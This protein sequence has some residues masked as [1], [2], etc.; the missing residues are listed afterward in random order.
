MERDHLFIISPPR[1]GSTFLYEVLSLGV[2]TIELGYESDLAW[3][4]ALPYSPQRGF[5]DFVEEKD[6]TNSISKKIY[7]ETVN[8]AYIQRYGSYIRY[9]LHDT[10]GKTPKIYLDKTIA[11]CFH[12]NILNSI[13]GE[14]KNRVKLVVLLRNPKQTISSMMEGWKYKDLMGKPQID[15]VLKRIENRKIEHWSFPIPPRWQENVN[16]PLHELCAWSWAQHVEYIF[17]GIRKNSYDYVL[18]KYE[19]MLESITNTIKEIE[20]NLDVN[21]GIDFDKLKIK[22]SR[23]TISPPNQDKWLVNKQLI[24]ESLSSIKDTIV[25]IPYVID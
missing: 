13:Y 9:K 24:Q 7:S 22:N 3:W 17:D 4:S 10:L 16:K 14:K 18:I 1:S 8:R 12:L 25:K 19:Q 20:V 21:L 6:L 2:N 5:S 23:T 11:N 15:G